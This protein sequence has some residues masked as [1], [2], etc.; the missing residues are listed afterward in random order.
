MVADVAYMALT[1]GI[2]Q[3]YVE[4]ALSNASNDSGHDSAVPVTACLEHVKAVVHAAV[5]FV[6]KSILQEACEMQL[7]SYKDAAKRIA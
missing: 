3:S 6:T 2:Q 1:V 5:R 7:S 4:E